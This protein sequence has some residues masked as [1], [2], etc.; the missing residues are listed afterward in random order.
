VRYFSE[1]PVTRILEPAE[2]VL[3]RYFWLLWYKLDGTRI[4]KP[5]E[6]ALMRYFRLLRYKLRGKDLEGP[7]GLGGGCPQVRAE[8]LIRQKESFPA[9]GQQVL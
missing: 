5:T 3:V 9:C 8:H 4:L 1:P 7:L 2:A 6:V